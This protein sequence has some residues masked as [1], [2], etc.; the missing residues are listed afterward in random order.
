MTTITPEETLSVTIVK[1]AI[2]HDPT[3]SPEKERTV[4]K[5]RAR[6]VRPGDIDLASKDR[7]EHNRVIDEVRTD[8]DV[9]TMWF[10]GSVHYR[11]IMADQRIT[12]AR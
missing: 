8:G 4:R 3:F 7:P 5:V 12:I 9:T 10:V 11:C 2:A 6:E 1:Q